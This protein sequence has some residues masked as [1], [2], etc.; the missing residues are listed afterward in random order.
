MSCTH[1]AKTAC[2]ASNKK[3]LKNKFHQNK[4]VIHPRK[5]LN[6]KMKMQ[7]ITWQKLIMICISDKELA[8]RIYKYYN[9]LRN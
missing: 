4:T 1:K 3:I 8:S 2:K 6:K 5:P 7:A 9:T